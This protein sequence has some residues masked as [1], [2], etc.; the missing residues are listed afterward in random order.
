MRPASSS[1]VLANALE[2]WALP[3]K[4]PVREKPV[5]IV[6]PSQALKCM[7][8]GVGAH[9][10]EGSVAYSLAHSTGGIL[11]DPREG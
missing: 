8:L 9:P 5:S 10:R 4:Q 11:V 2:P 3:R 6:L 7:G 1:K